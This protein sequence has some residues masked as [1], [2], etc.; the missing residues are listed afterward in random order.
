MPDIKAIKQ[1]LVHLLSTSPSPE[2]GARLKQRLNAEFAAKGWGTFEEKQYGYKRF[3]D[4]LSKG[5]EDILNVEQGDKTGDILVSLKANIPADVLMASTATH[6]RNEPQ[7]VVRNDVWQA[8][9][10]PDQAR[11]RFLNK[12]TFAIVHFL[13]EES[14]S[15]KAEVEL[16]PEDFLEIK[17]VSA[18]AQVGWM[19]EFLAS[20]ELSPTEK[21]SLE[22][23][24]KEPYSSSVN[25]IFT[26]ALG[27]N[28]TSWRTFRAEQIVGYVRSWC[29]QE[30]IPFEK[31]CVQTQQ[32]ASLSA[33]AEMAT[34]TGLSP[35][36]QVMSLMLLLTD[37]DISKLVIPTLLST[38]LVKSRM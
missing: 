15:A 9:S 6:A 8:F 18:E 24:T 13:A 5:Q 4:F 19:N 35:R 33:N 3:I 34:T 21:A 23:I 28:S 36:Q 22:A 20:A 12:K 30:S 16:A 26:R 38:I 25:A 31:L 29:K 10:N 7:A 17:P 14:G 2:L 27:T 11:R 37:E 32:R 1:L